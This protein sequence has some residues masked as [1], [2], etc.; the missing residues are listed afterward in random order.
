MTLSSRLSPPPADILANAVGRPAVQVE[1]LAG[2]GS[3]RC[4]YRIRSGTG[5]SAEAFV[6]MQL[7]AEDAKKL[8]EN[9][10]EWIEIARI[11]DASGIRVPRLHGTLLREAALIIED[12]GDITFEAEAKALLAAGRWA[13]VCSLYMKATAIISKFLSLSSK[14][15]TNAWTGRKFDRERYEFETDFFMHHFGKPIANISLTA[16]EEEQYRADLSALSGF[17]SGFSKYFVHRDYH[18]RNLMLKSGDI[19]VIDFQDAR[20]G[21]PAYDLVSLYFDS[22]VPMTVS[23]RLELMERGLTLLEIEASPAVV[24]EVREHWQACLLQRQLKAIGSFGYLTLVKNR[25]NYLKNVA[26]AFETMPADIVH[27]PRWPFLSGRLFEKIKQ[28]KQAD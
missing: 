5:A 25:G 28:F 11:L 1:W 8:S 15:P 24:R 18:S 12:Y 9:R 6:L 4:Y 27:D 10:Y 20:I 16:A 21:S 23:Q 7:S 2:D 19:A 13:E 22:Y 14:G 3:D 26:P 17:L